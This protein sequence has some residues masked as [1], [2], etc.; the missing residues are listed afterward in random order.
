MFFP[1]MLTPAGTCNQALSSCGVSPFQV[2]PTKLSLLFSSLA[3]ALEQKRWPL[4]S[5]AG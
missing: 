1:L 5:C 2:P 3:C 4:C